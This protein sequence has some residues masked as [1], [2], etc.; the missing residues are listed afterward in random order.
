MGHEFCGV[1]VE[2]SEEVKSLRLGDLV[3]S[4]FT[5]SWYEIRFFLSQVNNVLYLG[6]TLPSSPGVRQHPYLSPD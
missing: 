5:V 1:V 6:M 3:V 4:P 2:K